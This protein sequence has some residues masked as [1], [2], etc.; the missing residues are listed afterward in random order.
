MELESYRS[1]L[2]NRAGA[3]SVVDGTFTSEAFMAEAAEQLTQADEIENLEMLS[4]DGV[5]KRNRRLRVNGYDL[6]DSDGSVALSVLDFKGNQ[7]L[8]ELTFSEAQNLFKA[9]MGF[10]EQSVDGTFLEGRE[11]STAEF[12]L[13]QDLKNRGRS[14]TRYRLYLISDSVLKG[15]ARSIPSTEIN[16]IPVEFH[17]WDIRRLHQVAESAQGRE[18]LEIDLTTWLPDGLEALQT[19]DSESEFK[20]FLAAVPAALIAD[21]YGTYGSRLLEG[22]VRSYLSNRGNV[23]KGI[24]TT[25]KTAPA[26]FLAYNNGITATAVGAKSVAG[27]ITAVTDL[28]IV[29]GGQTTASLFYVRRDDKVDL[30][31]VYVQMKLIIVDPSGA[32]EMIPKIS[33]YANSQ[34]KISEADFFSNSPFHVRLAEL[35]QRVLAPP[36]P[37]VNYQTKWFY[38]RARG[39]YQSE[40]SK[41]TAAD[42]KKFEA[43]YPK[44]QLITKTDAAKYEVTWGMQPHKVS[45]GAQKNFVA[46]AGLVAGKWETASDSFNEL[47]WKNLVAKAILFETA[48]KAIAKADWYDKGYLANITTYALAKLSFEVGKQVR[49]GTFDLD[50]IWTEQA[51][52]E[53]SIKEIVDI[54]EKVLAVLTSDYRPVQNVT[55]WAKREACWNTVREM[56]HTL[57]DEFK[58]SMSDRRIVAQ[59]KKDAAKTQRIDDGIAAQTRVFSIEGSQWVAVEEFA[60]QNRLITEKELSIIALVTGRKAGFP[61]EMQS[62][63]LL[64]LLSKC[65]DNGFE[66]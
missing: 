53:V 8:E 34:N 17:I 3:R 46:F 66:F 4:F 54:G 57:S 15:S 55:E 25:V 2:L 21:L 65:E 61:T 48:R 56:E 32:A 26:H 22:N 49:G 39:Q 27:R 59:K 36:M 9:L 64:E 24:R 50:R 45:S 43:E 62:K 47:Y 29:N 42:Q 7:E 44:S 20:I 40:K 19:T 33:R 37:G 5:G 12:Q 6:D 16:S 51:V 18:E 13:A 10:L 52:S 63:V 23:N 30:N 28:Q 35:S 58:A 60:R 11:E 38:E 14:V 41:R 31:G 1:D